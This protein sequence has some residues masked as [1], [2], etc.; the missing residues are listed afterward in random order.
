MPLRYWFCKFQQS[1]L[2]QC[3]LIYTIYPPLP[4]NLCH[5]F[6]CTSFRAAA[7][8]WKKEICFLVSDQKI[9]IR[10]KCKYSAFSANMELAKHTTQWI[11]QL[12]P[13][14]KYQRA[15]LVQL[16]LGN[17]QF[18]YLTLSSTTMKLL[19]KCSKLGIELWTDT[20]ENVSNT[21]TLWFDQRVM[22]APRCNWYACNSFTQ[23]M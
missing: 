3:N 1:V 5:A 10:V 2:F 17:T 14:W 16:S 6:S 4:P 15:V 23:E 18:S 8:E 21:Q 7:K 11:A 22:L 19:N 12:P 20:C 9:K 13:G